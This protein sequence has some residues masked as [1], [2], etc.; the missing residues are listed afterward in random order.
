MAKT[1]FETAL[2]EDPT[3]AVV[4]TNLAAV[5]HELGNFEGAVEQ[6]QMALETAPNIF[7]ARYNL[8]TALQELD[9]HEEA[10][11]AYNEVLSH[12]PKHAA[13]AMNI[14]CGLQQMGQLKEASAAFERAISLD[15]GFPKAHVNH[16][17]LRLQQRDPIAALSICD[18]Y[19]DRYPGDTSLMAFKAIALGDAGDREEAAD[20]IDFDRFLQIQHIGAPAPH[21]DLASFNAALGAHILSHP[22]LNYAPQSHATRVGRHSGEL[23]TEPKGPFSDLE[24]LIWTAVDAYKSSVA[25]DATHPFLREQPESMKLSIWGV[26]METAGHQIPHIHPAAWLS[27][28]YYAKVPDVVGEETGERAGWI[29]LG[30]PPD[31]FHNSTDLEIRAI[32]PEAGLMLLFPSYFYH[33]TIP[34]QTNET[35]ISIAFDLIPT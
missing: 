3:L 12:Q 13:A 34:F 32:K 8:G 29:V 17:D 20:L 30:R 16:A 4:R 35:R 10:I 26:V 19:L 21:K 11:K 15:P 27:G 2:N 14:A 33:H 1:A 31:H 18:E 5:L 28:V 6:S 7:E 23:L 22:S 25:G 9:R 24:T